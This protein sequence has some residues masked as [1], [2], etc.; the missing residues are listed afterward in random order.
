MTSRQ[1][2][3]SIVGRSPSDIDG[4]A[5]L[6]GRA[7]YMSDFALPGMLYGK[8]LHS[9]VP[10]ARIRGID[11]SAALAEPGVA[12]IVTGADL[13]GLDPHYGINI[14]D[15]PVLAIDKV[16]YVGDAV[17][18]V[19]ACDETSALRALRKIRV[20]YE[21]LPVVASISAALDAAAPP[22]FDR[23]HAATMFPP[24]PG[25]R[26]V[27]EPA[28]NIL[29]DYAYE[30]GDVAAALASCEQ[31]FED[32]FSFARIS[33][34]TLEPHIVAA[35][36]SG[37]SVE[38]WANTQD[39]FLLR[40]DVARVFG[41]PLERVRFHAALIGGGFG[42]KS[43]CKIEPLAA[44]LA[45]KAER[46]VRLAHSMDENLTALCEHAAEI[47]MRTGLRGGRTILRDAIVRLDGGAYADASPSVA[48]RIGDRIG[49]PYR[50]EAVRC[51]VLVARTN[52]VP[53]G[54]FRGF[55]AVHVTWASESQIDM[56][57]HRLNEDPYALRRRNLMPLG[58][59]YAP[60]ATQ[61]D[62][63]LHAGLDAVAARI[64]YADRQR[65][66]GRGL[67]FAVGLKSAGAAHRA[68][69]VVRLE[70]SGCVIAASGVTEIGQGARSA[71]A[72]IVAEILKV[73]L[74]SVTVAAIDTQDTPFDAGTH[75]SCGVAVTGLAMQRAA[76]EARRKVLELG[77]K[78]LGTAP[79]ELAFRNFAIE[80][81]GTV[82]ALASLMARAGLPEGTELKGEAGV[83]TGSRAFWLPSWTAAEVDV[84]TE[85]GA[86]R[87]L[88]LVSAADAGS[89]INP[90][91]CRSQIEG[92]V[93]QGFGQALFEEL[94]YGGDAAPVNATPLGYRVSR[95]A[96]LPPEIEALVLEQGHGPGPFGSKGIG[97]AGNLAVAAAIANAVEDAVGARVTEL[98]ITPERV[99]AALDR[100]AAE[101]AG[102]QP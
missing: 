95:L 39:P 16:R 17:A 41:L 21:S 90:E 44:L 82:H 57:A 47:T 30:S 31:V 8:I 52:T 96:D 70:S 20:D 74:E 19:A 53:A 58:T 34:Y 36:W 71:M 76:E 73:P 64:G 77:A 22:L 100:A 94:V 32:R 54:S 35:A 59:A 15:Q 9:P 87:V 37:G 98:P 81:G 28:P 1:N 25:G 60:G 27:L 88:K 42:S 91:R 24:P 69:A 10:H 80:H 14:R 61:L 7:R 18:A 99:L 65:R 56:A 63:D 97:E 75:A 5:K 48:T 92:G 46:P 49:G 83:E 26:A 38:L 3:L 72:Q 67:G 43:Y 78:V 68:E 6:S 12:A 33:H 89:A 2:E 84:D 40:Q 29:Y 62:S 13:D 50:W 85:T 4:A 45:R 102:A 11:V 23:T 66:R 93:V 86:V 101:K 51:R 55:G 79:E